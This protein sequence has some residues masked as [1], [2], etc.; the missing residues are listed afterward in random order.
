M[1][2]ADLITDVTLAEALGM[3]LDKFHVMRRRRGWPCVKFGR[4]VFRFTP[5]QVE[6]IIAMQTVTHA[7]PVS[8][9]RGR[10]RS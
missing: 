6:Q 9:G 8:V 5:A 4:T 3:D 2:A 1:S 7:A 10:R